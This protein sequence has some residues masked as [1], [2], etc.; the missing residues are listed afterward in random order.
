MNNYFQYV[1]GKFVHSYCR[2]GGTLGCGLTFCNPEASLVAQTNNIRVQ[3]I[4][5]YTTD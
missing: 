4:S 3:K 2:P 1:S 5:Q